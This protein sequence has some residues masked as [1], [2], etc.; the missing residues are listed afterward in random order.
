MRSPAYRQ[1]RQHHNNTMATR[2]P[3]TASSTYMAANAKKFQWKTIY[4]IYL[5]SKKSISEGRR[6]SKAYCVENPT[7]QGLFE[8]LK[9]FGLPCEV[10]VYSLLFCLFS[11]LF[12][13]Y[14]ISSYLIFSSLPFS[15]L[16]LSSIL[17]SFKHISNV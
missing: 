7:L 4:P 15:S 11:P 17:F 14:L 12:F 9:T 2:P 1:V 13:S 8:G 10:E 5:N 16:L 3:T 6:M